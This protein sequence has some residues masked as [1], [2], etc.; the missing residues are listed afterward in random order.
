MR[1]VDQALT[2]SELRGP[3]FQLVSVGEIR[4]RAYEIYVRRGMQDGRQDEDWFEAEAEL[5]NET[6]QDQQQQSWSHL[7]GV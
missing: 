4:Q 5:R 7:S 1:T 3:V 6:R 2:E